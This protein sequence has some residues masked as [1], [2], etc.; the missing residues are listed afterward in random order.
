MALHIVQPERGC[1]SLKPL[2][3]KYLPER[4]SREHLERNTPW[5]R[6]RYNYSQ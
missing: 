2:L 3:G 5:T 6:F 1:Q 4:W